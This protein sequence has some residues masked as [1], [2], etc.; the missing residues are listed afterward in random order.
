V[1]DDPPPRPQPQPRPRPQ[2]S[3]GGLLEVLDLEELDT[4]LYRGLNEATADHR[5]TLFGGQVAAQALRAAAFTV[6]DGRLPNSLH[7]Y[8]LRPGQFERPVILRVDRDR[9]GRSFSARHVAA[10]QDGKVIF[11]LLASFHT[12]EEG[13]EFAADRSAGVRGPDELADGPLSVRFH[14]TLHIRPVPP[15]PP[16]PGEEMMVPSRMWL[17]TAESLPDDPL[18][19]ACALTYVSD[20]GSGFSNVDIG[21]SVQ[22]GPSI[23]HAVWFHHPLRLDDW[24]LLDMW[25]LKVSGARGLYSGAMTDRSGRLG[26]MLSQEVLFR[27]R[28]PS[29]P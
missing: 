26:A 3:A 9:D 19:H 23:D 12:P 21:G 4:D 6:P 8:F 5:S 10:M 29:M 25:P 22:G 27:E 20:V 14:R 15:E 11:D 18:I 7:G 16:R 17:R 24:V 13:M 28:R 1:P 2:P